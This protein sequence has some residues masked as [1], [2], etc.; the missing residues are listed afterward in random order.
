MG[1][2][3]ELIGFGDS[4]KEVELKSCEIVYLCMPCEEM[5]NIYGYNTSELDGGL[6]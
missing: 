2:S 3:V 1:G 4:T 6:P 5:F